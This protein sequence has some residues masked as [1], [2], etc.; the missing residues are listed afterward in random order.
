MKKTSSRNA[1]LVAVL[2]AGAFLV[3]C[4]DYYRPTAIPIV[5]PGGDP[6]FTEGA[7]ILTSNPLANGPSAVMNIDTTGETNVGNHFVGRGA[8]DAASLRGSIT[9][10]YSANQQDATISV[11]GYGASANVSTV[12]L[13]QG[14]V[15]TAVGTSSLTTM[16]V[17][18]T[19][20]NSFS[21]ANCPGSGLLGVVRGLV[22][23]AHVCVGVNPAAVVGSVDQTKLYVLNKGSDD[24]TV[25]DA[26]SRSVITTI[27]LPAGSAPF[28]GIMHPTR[29]TLFV[30]NG[31]GTVSVINT[32]YFTI[33]TT[34]GT[35][36]TAPS[37]MFY[38]N[39]NSRLAVANE[40]SNLVRIWEVPVDVPTTNHDVTVGAAPKSLAILPNG[41]KAYT[42]NSGDD[43]ISVIDM[44]TFTEK[45]ITLTDTASSPGPHVPVSLNVT[46]DSGRVLVANSGSR[47]VTIIRTNTDTE[48]PDLQGNPY[49]L[50]A[51]YQDPQCTPTASVPCARQSPVQV[52]TVVR[53]Q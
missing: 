51:P 5:K 52:L 26:A 31:N 22:L 38:D 48:V 10:T 14:S 19:G 18:M 9:T 42:A 35:G 47:D 11:A 36:G 49:R 20:N 41:S 8:V 44:T 7:V 1:T 25:V 21:D 23:E 45:T 34:V 39:H 29:P 40:G 53:N 15:P 27:A 30:L 32:T 3:S 4:G 2:L 12:T 6:A 17:T 24:V 16:Y 13:L 46:R 28:K 50:P 33:S 37:D 43:T